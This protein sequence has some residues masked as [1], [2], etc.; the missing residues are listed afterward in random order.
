MS[1]AGCSTP[2]ISP[3]MHCSSCYGKTTTFASWRP[4][5]PTPSNP[6]PPTPPPRQEMAKGRIERL[7]APEPSK[8]SGSGA[9]A[10]TQ[11]EEE[12]YWA[13]HE[14]PGAPEPSTAPPVSVV[15]DGF[16]NGGFAEPDPASPP[17]DASPAQPTAPP[18]PDI[19]R[20]QSLAGVQ[21]PGRDSYLGVPPEV[22]SLPRIGLEGLPELLSASLDESSSSVMGQ[23]PGSIDA[24]SGQPYA[25]ASS[26]FRESSAGQPS[27]SFLSPAGAGFSNL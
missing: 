14:L 22:G 19:R 3:M 23:K 5:T 1:R 10:A 7:P 13:Q 9:V 11:S 26:R 21:P 25:S 17:Q 20:R 6:S 24:T 15:N 4:C 2:L 16:S 18:Y 27:P 12:K 8:A